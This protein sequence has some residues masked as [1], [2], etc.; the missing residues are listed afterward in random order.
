[1]VLQAQ[2]SHRGVVRARVKGRTRAG[3][4]VGV[5]TQRPDSHTLFS[6]ALQNAPSGMLNAVCDSRGN[7]GPVCVM[8]LG[9][10][11]EACWLNA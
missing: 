4:G 10:G 11:Y 2:G 9:E 6:A 1:M 5:G 8:W 7:R 3:A